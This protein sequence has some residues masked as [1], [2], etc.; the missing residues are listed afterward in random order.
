M[1]LELLIERWF[2]VGALIFGLSHL[3]YPATWAALFLPLRERETGALLLGTFNL[4]LGLFLI[5]GHNIWRWGPPVIVTLTAWLMTLKSIVYLL[6]PRALGRVM[7]SDVRM[8]RA[9]RIAGA[10]MILMGVLLTYDTFS[11]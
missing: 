1:S 6:F 4:L 9:F 5:L 8:Q 2:A 11:Q 10:V 3:L 7:P